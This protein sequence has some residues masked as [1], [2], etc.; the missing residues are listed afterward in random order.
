MATLTTANSVFMLGV[1]NLY[2]VPVKIE[3][4][5]TDDSFMAEDVTN[6][7][8]MMGLDGKMSAPL[9]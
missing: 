4:Y 9:S 8:V 5:T 3:G 1:A 2:N 6:A 7:E